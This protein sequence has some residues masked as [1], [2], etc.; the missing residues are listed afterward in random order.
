MATHGEGRA[1]TPWCLWPSCTGVGK[2][3][4]LPQGSS[5]APHPSPSQTLQYFGVSLQ[6]PFRKAAGRGKKKGMK[7]E[8]QTD[9][10]QSAPKRNSLWLQG[11]RSKHGRVCPEMC[12]GSFPSIPLRH[13]CL[14]GRSGDWD[15]QI[16]A[17]AIW[18]YPAG[19][20]GT[21]QEGCFSFLP[22]ATLLSHSPGAEATDGVRVAWELCV[23]PGAEAPTRSSSLLGVGKACLGLAVCGRQPWRDAAWV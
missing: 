8:K 12:R 14:Q 19:A 21:S 6:C 2:I 17:P 5:P 1:V 22:C 23:A 10:G 7:E 16:P 15:Y 4:Y 18:E 11:G 9:K 3:F 20:G 13:S